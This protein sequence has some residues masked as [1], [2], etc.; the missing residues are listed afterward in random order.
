MSWAG[1]VEAERADLPCGDQIAHDRER[2]LDVGRL[3]G[4]VNLVQV[5]PVG[6]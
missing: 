4:T 3:I 6:L 1:N 5:Q 2:L